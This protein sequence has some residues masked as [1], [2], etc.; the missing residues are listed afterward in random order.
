MCWKAAMP[1]RHDQPAAQIPQNGMAAAG[2]TCSAFYY[3]WQVVVD[4]TRCPIHSPYRDLS[5]LGGG[6]NPMDGRAK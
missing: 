6:P 2:C 4:R 1:D 3:G 5:P